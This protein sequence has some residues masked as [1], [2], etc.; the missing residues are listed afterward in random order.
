MAEDGADNSSFLSLALCRAVSLEH[1]GIIFDSFRHR[2]KCCTY[3][4]LPVKQGQ[5]RQKVHC[6]GLSRAK[7]HS[8]YSNIPPKQTH[9]RLVRPLRTL[10]VN[11]A[12]LTLRRRGSFARRAERALDGCEMKERHA[13]LYHVQPQREESEREERETEGREREGEEGQGLL[14]ESGSGR[15]TPFFP[16]VPL[17]PSRLCLARFTDRRLGSPGQRG[18]APRGRE[19]VAGHPSARHTRSTDAEQLTGKITSLHPPPHPTTAELAGS[20]CP[21]CTRARADKQRI[22][23]ILGAPAL[24]WPTELLTPPPSN[25][26]ALGQRAESLSGNSLSSSDHSMC[27][28]SLTAGIPSTGKL[29]GCT[30]ISCGVTLNYTTYYLNLRNTKDHERTAALAGWTESARLR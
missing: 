18:S 11:H 8:I 12:A 17:V 26:M 29:G 2:Q 20:K 7:I 3:A 16:S 10:S 9:G 19:T 21:R 14:S 5:Q 6:Q 28:D 23:P 24:F 25:P 30:V 15:I 4:A 13:R 27:F 1:V 22:L